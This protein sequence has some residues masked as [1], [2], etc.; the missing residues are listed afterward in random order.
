MQAAVKDLINDLRGELLHVLEN[1]G[2]GGSVFGTDAHLVVFV[3]SAS[4]QFPFREDAHAV[5][6]KGRGA[7]RRER[8]GWTGSRHRLLVLQQRFR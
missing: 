5:T 3:Q 1:V 6:N 8:R 7:L 4:V 2:V